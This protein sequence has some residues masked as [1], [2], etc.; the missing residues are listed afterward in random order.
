MEQRLNNKVIV[1]AGG[2]RG[3]GRA[4]AEEFARQGAKVVIGDLDEESA[5]RSIRLMRT[6][7]SDGHFVYTDLRDIKYCK[8]LFEESYNKFGKI[9][10]FFMYSGVT[11][12][13]PLDTCNEEKLEET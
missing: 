8:I 6:Y 5:M 2:T 7:G 13:S 11:P 3:V 10:G 1:I 9:D 12:I 4:A